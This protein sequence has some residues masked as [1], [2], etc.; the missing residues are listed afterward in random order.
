MDSI[1]TLL[2]V[3]NHACA[4]DSLSVRGERS[5]YEVES[6]RTAKTQWTFFIKFSFLFYFA[7]ASKNSARKQQILSF[8]AP[9]QKKQRRAEHQSNH[10]D[11]ITNKN[12]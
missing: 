11:A 10:L 3:F 6:I 7:K 12:D 1:F 8:W 9:R 5:E 2:T 4:R